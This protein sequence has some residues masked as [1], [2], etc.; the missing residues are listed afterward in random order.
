MMNQSLLF[1]LSHSPRQSPLATE[2]LDALMTAVLL[3]IE[4]DVALVSNG[5]ELLED[6]QTREQLEQ[7][8][9]MG[10]CNFYVDSASLPQH[11]SAQVT[12]RKQA[13][14]IIAEDLTA[15]LHRH[16]RVLSF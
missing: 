16:H 5:L 13:P 7:I 1:V 15:L 2:A 4:T 3:G 12:P 9:T 8:A 10:R 11:E 6:K 14:E